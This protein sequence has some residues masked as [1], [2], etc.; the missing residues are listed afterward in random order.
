ML[1]LLVLSLLSLFSVIMAQ[2]QGTI[3]APAAG[4]KIK[5]KQSFAFAY[6][7]HQDY[8]VS[9]NDY[10]RWIQAEEVTR[11]PATTSL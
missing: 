11:Y 3:L 4:A 6:K 8:C 10:P 2:N 5:P 1:A 9:D 7:V